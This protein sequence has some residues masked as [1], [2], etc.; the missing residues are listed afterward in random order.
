[1][2]RGRLPLTALR[3][4]E[5]AG[6]LQSFT[7]AAEELHISQAAV[8]RQVR[9]LEAILGLALFERLHR[10]VRLTAAGERLLAVLTASLDEIDACLEDLRER[11][12]GSPLTISAEPSFAA[13]W[14][15]PNIA[16]FQQNNPQ[17]DV[18]LEADPRLVEFRSSRAALAIRH[19]AQ[20][21]NWPRVES[22]H[23]VDVRM[24]PVVSPAL[25]DEGPP[26]NEP[27]DLLGYLLLHEEC[28][29]LWRQWFVAAGA[30]PVGGAER[31]LVYADGGLVLQAAL[32]GQGAALLD[33]LFVEED[34]R[35]GR[36][37]RPFDISIAH[38]AYFL[39]ARRFDRLPEPASAFVRWMESRFAPRQPDTGPQGRS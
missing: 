31:G 15:L 14:L 7:L 16:G 24:T 29:D 19:S 8:S 9:E 35:A 17:V 26:M 34:V 25:L 5:V 28:R 3:S 39:V 36:L 32:R 1:M 20:A 10:S 2:K 30:S 38:G 21:T 22:R 13:C 6:R 12:A 33:E 18:N 27:G 37:I 11:R 4:F 23:L